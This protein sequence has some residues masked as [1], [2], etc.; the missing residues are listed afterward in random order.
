MDK[1][2]EKWEIEFDKKFDVYQSSYEQFGK[3]KQKPYELPFNMPKVH[4][5]VEDIKS[6]VHSQLEQAREDLLKLVENEVIGED[7]WK[8]PTN[9]SNQNLPY[10][11]EKQL[12]RNEFRAEQRKKLDSLK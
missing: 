8:D 6:F 1:P 9:V 12:Y 2:K 4:C 3:F 7:E 5:P 10:L 11:R